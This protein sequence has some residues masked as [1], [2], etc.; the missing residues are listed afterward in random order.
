MKIIVDEAEFLGSLQGLRSQRK[1][2]S[3][4]YFY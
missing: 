2:P 3:Y 1:C 4:L